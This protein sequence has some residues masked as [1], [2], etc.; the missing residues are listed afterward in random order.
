VN[1][2]QV[3]VAT[4]DDEAALFALINRAFDVE[5]FFMTRDRITPAELAEYFRTGLFIVLDGGEG[6]LNA[7]LYF[8]QR[9][10]HAYVGMLAVDPGLQGKGIGRQMMM[11]AER[12]ALSLGCRAV[13]IRVVNLRQELPP[14]Y[15]ALGYV[16]TGTQAADVSQATQPFHFVLMSKEL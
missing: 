11:A 3:R 5:R 6:Q 9:G 4:T 12:H 13:D 2:E 1:V 16:E 15:H 8:E 14:F 7:C 10:D